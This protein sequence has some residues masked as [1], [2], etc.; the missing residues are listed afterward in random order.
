MMLAGCRSERRA[1]RPSAVVWRSVGSWSGRGNAQTESFEIGFEECR[2]RWEAR[3]ETAR[4]GRLHVTVNSAV[5]G[6]E[7]AVA[8]DHRGA[9]QGIAY[10]GV[11]PHLSY[12]LIESN[13]L[14]WSLTVEEPAAAD[15]PDSTTRRP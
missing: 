4:A 12:L 13:N 5:S 3:D 6:R 14:A 1:T 2:I 8:I 9:G 7:L 15:E 11:D 10:V